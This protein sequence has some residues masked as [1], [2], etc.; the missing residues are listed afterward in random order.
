M[1]CIDES[2]IQI[3]DVVDIVNDDFVAL[4][5]NASEAQMTG[6]LEL[7]KKNGNGLFLIHQCGF[8]HL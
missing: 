6:H 3:K 4:K 7:S 5:A 2:H 1:V 8:E